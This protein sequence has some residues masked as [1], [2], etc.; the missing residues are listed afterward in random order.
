MIP[1]H[2]INQS[3]WSLSAEIFIPAASS[4][5]VSRDQISQ[6]ISSGLEVIS[7]GANVPF[8]DKEIFFG[9]IAKKADSE[10]SLI[11]DFISNCGM[12]RTFSYLMEAEIKMDDFAIFESVSKTIYEALLESNKINNQKTNLSD[13]IGPLIKVKLGKSQ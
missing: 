3:I 9:P 11:P 1:F 5:L 6:M 7:P 2:E 4:R 13:L 12:A 10:I 8:A